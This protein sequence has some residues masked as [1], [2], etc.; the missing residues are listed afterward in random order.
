MRRDDLITLLPP[1]ADSRAADDLLIR[2]LDRAEGRS[3]LAAWRAARDAGFAI[4]VA[5]D[6]ELAMA[7]SSQLAGPAFNQASGLARLPNLID[8]AIGFYD[9]HATPGWLWLEEEPWPDAEEALDLELFGADP[10]EV[11]GAVADGVTLRRIGPDEA[12]LATA[13]YSGNSTAGGMA[14]GAPNP[15]PAVYE[16]LVRASARQMFIA[17]VHG[18]AVANASLH[19]SART[20]WLRGALTAPD[21]RG[22]G[23]QSA[24][25]SLRAR[26]AAEAG[27]DLVGASAEPGSVSAGNLERL[28]FRRLGRRV[29]YVYRPRVT[30]GRVAEA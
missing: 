23:I 22:R 3:S 7:A 10:R 17:E 30:E 27:C 26:V 15:W 4:D 16:Q 21:A 11:A 6:G 13:V 1:T 8:V 19:V 5:E 2:R 28:G 20:G 9:R 24:L 25:I 18:K 29:S 14:E 12:A